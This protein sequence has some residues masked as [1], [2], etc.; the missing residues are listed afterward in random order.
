MKHSMIK[1]I[2]AGIILF[3][4]FSFVFIQCALCRQSDSNAVSTADDIKMSPPKK[5]RVKDKIYVEYVK[6]PIYPEKM[7]IYSTNGQDEAHSET[8]KR[9]YSKETD[10]RNMVSAEP[11]KAGIWNADTIGEKVLIFHPGFSYLWAD[12]RYDSDGNSISDIDLKRITLSAYGF[13]G[14]TKRFEVSSHFGLV[15]EHIEQSGSSSSET[16]ILDL[17]LNGRYALIDRSKDNNPFGLTAGLNVTLPA[18][19]DEITGGD[20]KFGP[21]VHMVYSIGDASIYAN[22]GYTFRGS[23]DSIDYGNIFEYNFGGE[24]FFTDFGL[25]FILAFPGQFSED[26][27]I[28][29]ITMEDSGISKMEIVPAFTYSLPNS[30]MVL[31]GGFS[32]TLF[33]RSTVKSNTIFITLQWM[34]P[35]REN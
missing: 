8:E 12:S 2:I 15:S 26:M 33:G 1:L 30:D 25:S 9:E 31:V 16:G 24:Y 19:N 6:E 14:I 18:G 11:L 27:K 3:V 7:D 13:Y 4:G 32:L 10:I 35:G 20:F 22:M 29:G 34:L 23:N 17:S 21:L 28:D 5:I